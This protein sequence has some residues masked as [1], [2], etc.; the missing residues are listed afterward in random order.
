MIPQERASLCFL[1]VAITKLYLY[2]HVI[3]NRL[4]TTP[5]PLPLATLLTVALGLPLFRGYP[6]VLV[7]IGHRRQKY[8]SC[9][10]SEK[11]FR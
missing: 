8:A 5:M 1:H 11:Y 9:W 10:P 3:R 7:I 6:C 4:L 2:A